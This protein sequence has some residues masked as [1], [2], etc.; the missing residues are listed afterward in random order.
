MYTSWLKVCGHLINFIYVLYSYSYN[1]LN[2]FEDFTVNLWSL[3]VYRKVHIG[4][5]VILL[6]TQFNSFV[7]YV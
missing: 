2:S 6:A 7:Y 3:L 1:K 5:K 4:V